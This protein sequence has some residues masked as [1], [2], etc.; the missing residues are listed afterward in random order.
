[1]S[2]VVRMWYKKIYSAWLIPRHPPLLVVVVQARIFSA[3]FPLSPA[4]FGL[5][6]EHL[7]GGVPFLLRPG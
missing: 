5:F 1:M 4:F 7:Q 3:A 2:S 6:P